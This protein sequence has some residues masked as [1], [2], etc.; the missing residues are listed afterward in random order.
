M[1]VQVKIRYNSQAVEGRLSCL[2]ESHIRIDFAE[3][4]KS[5]TPGQSAVFYKDDVVLGGAII[6]Q[7]IE[8]F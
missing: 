5:V 8:L 7:P 3:A 6:D 4:Q 2:D 1:E